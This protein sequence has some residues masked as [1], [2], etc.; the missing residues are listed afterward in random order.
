MKGPCLWLHPTPILSHYGLNFSMNFEKT[1][2]SPY[3]H[4]LKIIMYTPELDWQF[5][6]KVL[7]THVAE[8]SFQSTWNLQVSLSGIEILTIQCNNSWNTV[9][10]LFIRPLFQ[11][12]F[13]AFTEW[14]KYIFYEVYFNYLIFMLMKFISFIFVYLS[15]FN[16][17]VNFTFLILLED[18]Q[19]PWDS[20]VESHDLPFLSFLTFS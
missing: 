5:S 19:M 18:P 15:C 11:Q 6:H 9:S 20:M 10:S 13:A 7:Y 16:N 2:P 1:Q 4:F 8:V 14:A 12:C 17:F 3:H